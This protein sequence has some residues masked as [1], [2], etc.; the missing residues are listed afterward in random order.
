MII[1]LYEHIKTNVPSIN[2]RIYPMIMPQNTT[3]PAMVYT[4]IND[5]DKQTISGCVSTTETLFQL[6]I[7][8]ES[9]SQ[10][11][12]IL[13]E[14]KS[15]LYTFDKYPSGLNSRDNY[16]EDTQLF[17]QLIQFTIRN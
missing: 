9:Y 6:D 1:E 4:V 17:R 5:N 16:E 12:T 2:N 3:K 7:Y 15:A 11:K 13:A 10:A 8:A 14:V